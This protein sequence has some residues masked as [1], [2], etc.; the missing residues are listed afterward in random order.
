MKIGVILPGNVPGV[1]G[2]TILDWCR[3]A[4]ESRFSSVAAADRLTY[5]NLEPMQLLA[6]AAAAT[7]RVRVVSCIAIAPLRPAPIFA[8][9]VATVAALAPGRFTL[10]VGTGARATDYGEAGVDFERRSR[11]LTEHLEYLGGLRGRDDEQQVGPALRELEVLIGGARPQSLERLI[12][13][14]DGYISGGIKPE[15]YGYEVHATREAWRAAGKPGEPRIV[16]GTFWASEAGYERCCEAVDSYMVQGGPPPPIR[17]E[18]R[19]GEEGV[20]A[21]VEE[22][23]AVGFDEIIFFPHVADVAEIERLAQIVDG[24]VAEPVPA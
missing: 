11:I 8:K 9:Q 3:I 23:G 20:R 6:F 21:A 1:D 15:V 24:L 13:F 16:A 18:I 12:R 5:A 4:D 2:P 17:D 14:G 7:S 19:R 10:G 22:F